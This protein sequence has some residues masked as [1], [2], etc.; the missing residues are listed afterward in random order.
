MQ[1]TLRERA[2]YRG[3]S[4]NDRCLERLVVLDAWS[5][6]IQRMTRH[7]EST[8]S[9]AAERKHAEEAGAYEEALADRRYAGWLRRQAAR[10][11]A[12]AQD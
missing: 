3:N 2:R 6:T 10:A 7:A 4:C 1:G 5:C 9:D 12:E 8:S 11:E